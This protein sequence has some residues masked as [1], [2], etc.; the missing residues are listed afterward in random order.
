MKKLILLLLAAAVAT[1]A[2]AQAQRDTLTFNN[3]YYFSKRNVE[4]LVPVTGQNIVMLGNSLTERGFWAEYFQGKRVLNRGI[5]GD[6]ISG[7]I[8]R[9]QPIVDGRP[10]AIFIMGGANDLLFSKISNEKLLQQ[11][12]RLLDIIARGTPRTRVY[13]QSLLPLNEAHNEAFMKGKNA[14]F[15]EFNALLRAM[16]ERRRADLHR[17]LERYAAQRGTARRVHVRRHP[18]QGGGLCRVDREDQALRQISCPDETSV[19]R[20]GIVRGV[21]GLHGRRRHALL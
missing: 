5:G 13:I 6:C 2:A 3:D 1:T 15:A 4:E 18:P 10:K 17:H 12:E 19:F 20:A 8:N 14:R 21:G 16:A 9:V 7:M 11:Y